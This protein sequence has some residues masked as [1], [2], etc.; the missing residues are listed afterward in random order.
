MGQRKVRHLRF[1]DNRAFICTF[2]CLLFLAPGSI[3]LRADDNTA[4]TFDGHFNKL[5]EIRLETDGLGIGA[6]WAFLADE[7]GCLI[8]LDNKGHQLLAFDAQGKFLKRI[9]TRGQGPGEFMSP[10][11]ICLDSR[12]NL[13]VADSSMRRISTFDKD[14]NF[15]RSFIISAGHTQPVR[16]RVD[17][18][19]DVIMLAQ[20]TI[21]R[22]FDNWKWLVRYTGDGKYVRSF[23]DDR[24]GRVWVSQLNPNFALDMKNDLIYTMQIHDY[25]F[26][27]FDNK[28]EFLRSLGKAPEY[29]RPPDLSYRLDENKYNTRDLIFDELMRLMGSWT[30]I[31]CLNVVDDSHIL[32][33]TAANGLVKGC[34]GKHLLDLWTIDGKPAVSGIPTDYTFLCSDGQG[35]MY[36]LLRSD[37]ESS[38][39]KEPGYVIGVYELKTAAH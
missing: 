17:S 26:D 16:I 35:R 12:G 6:L 37:E 22:D 38:L 31:V 34:S 19:G 4:K 25:R 11:A 2:F 1:F 10:N 36:F 28:G 29:F 27:V 23:G 20:T 9:G 32:V 8:F 39:D 3:K 14:W 18:Q 13:W 21:G 7:N 5:K 24:S 30:R 33:M 15:V